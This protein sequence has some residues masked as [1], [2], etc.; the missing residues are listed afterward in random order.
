VYIKN[1]ANPIVALV[2]LVV[3]EILVNIFL[4]LCF[5]PPFSRIIFQR[6]YVAG[7]NSFELA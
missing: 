4:F 1:N 3:G 2:Q 6:Q 7:G 5:I